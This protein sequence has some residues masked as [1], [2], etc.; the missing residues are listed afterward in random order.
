MITRGNGKEPPEIVYRHKDG[1]YVVFSDG[2]LHWLTLSERCRLILGRLTADD[3]Q[4]KYHST[5]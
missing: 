4:K 3:L 1:P 2:Q 5:P